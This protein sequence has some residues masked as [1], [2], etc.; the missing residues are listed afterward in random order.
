[1]CEKARDEQLWEEEE[2][3]AAEGFVIYFSGSLIGSRVW[4]GV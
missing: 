2:E 3:R 4:N 1:M